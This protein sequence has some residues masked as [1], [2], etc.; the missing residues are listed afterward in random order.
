MHELSILRA[1]LDAPRRDCIIE[2]G[3]THSF[4]AVAERARAAIDAL[5]SEG[6]DEDS[7]VVVTPRADLDTV[8]RL[9]SLFEM[10]LPVVLLHPRLSER[11]RAALLEGV[12]ARFQNANGPARD[13]LAVVYTSGTTGEPR[14]AILSRRAFIASAEAHAANLG[15]A[16]DDRWLLAIPPAHIGGFSILTR[17]LIARRG[18]VL[19]PGPFD[20]AE[21]AEAMAR[22]RVTLLS[23]VPTMLRRLTELAWKPHAELRAVL[24]G[25]AAFPKTL[26]R[27]AAELG[28]P[29]LATYGCTETCSQVATQRLDQVGTEGSGAPLDGIALRIRDDE[30]QVRGDVVMDGYLGAPRSSETWTDDG[31][32]AHR[33]S[34]QDRG[35]W[36]TPG[37]RASRRSD[38]DRRRKRFPT[39]SGS[40]DGVC[41]G[42]RVGLRLRRSRR[43]VG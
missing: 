19:A 42:R 29:V 21:L 24:V 14:G 4:S 10:G 11:E 3:E 17:S 13:T 7:P 40:V 34:R 39:R 1:A 6:V 25:G 18:V 36:P 41:G 5:R 35:G 37:A 16:H 2:G 31:W 22:D 26:R 28:V 8:V 9:Y 38:R 15:W 23:V 12:P 27:K 20:A 30:I 32:F 43:R 33:R